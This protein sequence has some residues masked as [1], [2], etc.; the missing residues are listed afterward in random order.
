MYSSV[1][2]PQFIS[3]QCWNT[4]FN[5]V[6]SGKKIKYMIH[7]I[8][9]VV[10]AIITSAVHMTIS[11]EK[12]S[13]SPQAF[14]ECFLHCMAR[15][16]CRIPSMSTSL[17]DFPVQHRTWLSSLKIKR[18]EKN[19]IP[20]ILFCSLVETDRLSG[21]HCSKKKKKHVRII[22]AK[23]GAFHRYNKAFI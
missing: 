19:Q 4:S 3:F 1:L 21:L 7:I 13:S 12:N 14:L 20:Y 18:T 2:R 11:L 10:I 15:S 17:S 5:T 16:S 22:Y 23:M 6:S 8:T 9:S